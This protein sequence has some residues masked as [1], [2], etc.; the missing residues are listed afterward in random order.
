MSTFG[1]WLDTLSRDGGDTDRMQAGDTGIPL[2]QIRQH[3]HTVEQRD[4]HGNAVAAWATDGMKIEIALFDFWWSNAD[5]GDPHYVLLARLSGFVFHPPTEP[6]AEARHLW[7]GD[8]DGYLYYP[9]FDVL[10]WWF[11]V[12]A[13]VYGETQARQYGAPV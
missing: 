11:G 4:P 5:R 12:V 1:A 6:T 10:A 2:A 13:R 9:D 7:I 3:A 8:R